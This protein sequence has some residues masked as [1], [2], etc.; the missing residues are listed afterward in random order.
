MSQWPHAKPVDFDIWYTSI[1]AVLA[2][3]PA[4]IVDECRNPRR[5]LSKVREFPPT[6]ACVTEWCDA[7][8]KEYKALAEYR[9][10]LARGP[11]PDYSND[12]REGMLQRLSTLLHDLFNPKRQLAWI[13]PRGRFEQPGDQWDRKQAPPRPHPKQSWKPYTLE[14]LR[15][16]YPV[17]EAANQSADS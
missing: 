6:I 15:A 8:L 11:E 9:P 1:G 10:L 5:G 14:E 4:V 16:R 3:Y 17:K 2:E 12:H 13:R 7:R